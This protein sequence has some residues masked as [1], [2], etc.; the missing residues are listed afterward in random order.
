MRNHDLHPRVEIAGRAP[1]VWHPLPTQPQPP[2]ARG[3]GGQPDFRAAGQGGQ[4]ERGAESSIPGRHG[5]IQVQ[6]SS[7]DAERA[8]RPEVHAQIQIAC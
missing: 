4:F 6:V 2:T 3:S 8:M 1:A 7:I 5:D